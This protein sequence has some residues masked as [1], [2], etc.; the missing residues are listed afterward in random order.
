VRAWMSEPWETPTD[1]SRFT[2][3]ALRLFAH[4]FEHCAPYRAFC[5][6]RGVRPGS[7]ARWEDV[8][9][10]PTGAFKAFPLR[11][12]SASATRQTFRTSGTTGGTRGELHLDTTAL[13]EDSL[14]ASFARGVLADCA[15]RVRMLIL[16]PSL[17]EASDS[18]LSYMF[19]VMLRER[20]APGSDFF[21]RDGALRID[22]CIDALSDAQEAR[23][24]VLVAGTAFAFVHLIDALSSRALAFRLGSGARIME[25]G[26]FKGRS[27]EVPRE[28]L[29][30]DLAHRLGIPD[31]R[32]VN[33]YG[34]TE[35]GSQF[36][37]SSIASPEEPRRKLVPPW[38]RVSALRP[39][40]HS[41]CAL[42]EFGMLRI[43]DLA[44][45]GSVAAVQT[46]D[47]GRCVAGGFEIIGR[48]AGS[49]IRGCS[50]AADASLG[51]A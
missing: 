32:I 39:E 26:G 37:D 15:G 51:S 40:D 41:V 50:V 24:P 49:D 4:Q 33:Q 8:P 42:G 11:S 20:G 23:E 28:K 35:L 22:A 2:A 14:R 1:E 9:P 45:T 5:E 3:L 34:M 46:A 10:V 19:D 48:S 7:V 27:R 18:S 44:N 13:Y 43:H 47:L 36:Y 29:Y 16:A 31:G 25:T 12:F 6:A 38:V 17:G 21:L 30:A